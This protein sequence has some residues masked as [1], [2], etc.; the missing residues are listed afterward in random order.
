MTTN[1]SRAG[2]EFALRFIRAQNDP[3][4]FAGATAALAELAGIDADQPPATA[5]AR[6]TSLIST[7]SSLIPMVS[8]PAGSF[9]MGSPEG[10][11]GRSEIEGP[12]HEVTLAAFWMARTPITQAQ[13]REVASWQKQ[14]RDLD[15]DPSRFKGD[16]RPVERVSWLDAIEFCNRL[17]QRTGKNY[18]LPSEA[19]W[20]YACRAGTTTPFNFGLTINTEAANYD[21][22]YTY[23]QGERGTYREQTTD[24]ASFPANPWGLYD[25]HGNVWE[26]CLDKWRDSYEGAPADGS[27]WEDDRLGESSDGCCAAGRGST[28]PGT[29][30]RLAASTTTRTTATTTSVS[31]SVASDPSDT[32]RLLRG[33]SWDFGPAN[34]RSAC[35]LN[36]RPGD[37]NNFFGFRVCCLPQD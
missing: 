20:E 11:V 6:L 19:Q 36:L 26:W 30:A 33:G 17:S 27:A 9:L 16:N 15:P 23:G 25:M 35:R 7:V 13:W 10:E 5:A 18:T 22:N 24:V 32:G 2:F 1:S 21:G 29:A 8:I 34:C 37:R 3:A 31:A 14:E 12:Q 4:L 28:T